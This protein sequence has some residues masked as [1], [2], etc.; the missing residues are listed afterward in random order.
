MVNV[1]WNQASAYAAW[2]GKRLP[3]EAEFEY[4]MRSGA[5]NSLYPWG[6]SIAAGN[7]NFNNN[8]GTP[9]AAGTY[10]A[11]SYG[12]FDIAGNVW[13]W[14]SDW[15]QAVLTGPVTDPFGPNSGTY[16]T[17]RSGSFLNSSYNLQCA[18]R[19]FTSAGVAYVDVGFRC[20][21]SV[22]T[23]GGGSAAPIGEEDSNKNGIVDWW[24]QMYF[25]LGMD[26]LGEPF[27]AG[28]DSDAD[29]LK[30][31][32][33]YIAGTDPIQSSSV[34]AIKNSSASMSGQGF[35]IQWSSVAGRKYIIERCTN[36]LDGF[37][38]IAADIDA[39]EPLNTYTDTSLP[40]DVP[41][42]YRVGIAQ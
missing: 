20:A 29:G 31:A 21:S 42:Y 36:L 23:A 30:N 11:N 16:K 33:E 2:A 7:A 19:W 8:V 39:A 18:P 40:A 35:T 27:E 25:G 14:C 37:Q 1:S 3:R 22:G 12:A 15:Y 26:G 13:E 4:V 17:M 5:A 32:D 28:A 41:A 38:V 6:N 24:E 9:T 34:L 10:A